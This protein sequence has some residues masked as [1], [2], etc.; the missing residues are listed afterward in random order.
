VGDVMMGNLYPEPWLPPDDG[1]GLFD[2]V[3]FAFR[4][5]DLVLANLEG[6]LYEGDGPSKC[7]LRRQEKEREE[8]RTGRKE[9]EPEKRLC[10]AFRSPVRYAAHLSRA[11]IGAVNVANNHARDFLDAGVESTLSAL[12]DAA[13]AAVG[14]ERVARFTTAAGTRVAVL[15]FSYSAPS[16][17]TLSLF[18]LEGAAAA[19]RKAREEAKIVVVSFHGGAEGKEAL[20]IP[21][22]ME[23][24]AGEKRGDV[25]A[26]AHA[27]V[28]AG[29]HLVVGH[30]PHVPRAMELY[31]G[32][33]V[34]YSLGNFLAYG[35]FN[36][37][38][39]SGTGYVLQADLD[40]RTGDFRKGRIVAVRLVRGGIPV[41]DPGREAV[42][43]VRRLTRED[44]GGGG[45]TI[46]D[47]GT[48]L[49]ASTPL[50]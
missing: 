30:G 31:R 6:T 10:Y 22:G 2:A 20:R 21:G 17:T 4:G 11:G 48:V 12:D 16:R 34:A 1:R 19:I 14:G 47:D 28:D 38:G 5:R 26:F 33:L 41:P 25:T 13:V 36:L 15:G 9:P 18:D 24:F 23:S 45:L 46:R 50:P 37:K 40:G 49:P 7:D 42:R 32:K 39:E 35:W 27:A 44:R 29:A 43:I 8:R 3:A